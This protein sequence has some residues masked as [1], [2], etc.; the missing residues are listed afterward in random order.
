MS[1][2]PPCRLAAATLV[3]MVLWATSAHAAPITVD[4][5]VVP[6][7]FQEIHFGDSQIYDCEGNVYADRLCHSLWDTGLTLERVG[8]S[9]YDDKWF[10]GY[11]IGISESSLSPTQGLGVMRIRPECKA[12][13]SPCFD[14]FTPL[15]IQIGGASSGSDPLPNLF[16][17]SSGGGLLKFP[18]L[19][20]L[21]SIDLIGDE[22]RNL[23]WLEYGFYM[24]AACDD[25]NP[26]AD[27][28][29]DTATEKA[30]F[31]ENL[32][33]EPVPEPAVVWLLGAA[34]A[35][36]AGRARLRRKA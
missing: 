3:G 12:G 16:I 19:D 28:V 14:L 4:W 18:S 35:G 27:L 26:P 25:A 23:S 10:D 21:T 13:L 7:Q 1:I 24:P 5:D 34:A 11:G 15:Q 33:F 8:F 30:L 22:W 9:F 36:V 20:G 31:L 32:T 2:T 17:T 29:C 6:H